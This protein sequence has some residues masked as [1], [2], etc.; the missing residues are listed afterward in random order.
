MNPDSLANLAIRGAIDEYNQVKNHSKEQLE[1]LYEE[2][3][4]GSPKETTKEGVL[5]E[6]IMSMHPI[7]DDDAKFAE[8]KRVGNGGGGGKK[9][10]SSKKKKSHKKS[11]K[12]R[13]SKRKPTKRRSK[14]R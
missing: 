3:F 11:K 7:V 14:R 5:K 12:R 13:K 2:E 4:G 8:I 9:R 10:K 1:E 6:Y